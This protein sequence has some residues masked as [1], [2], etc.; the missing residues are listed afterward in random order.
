[1]TVIQASKA[2]QASQVLTAH[3]ESMESM[4]L[5]AHQ[6]PKATPGQPGLTAQ[7]DP[8]DRKVSRGSQDSGSRSVAHCPPL[9]IYRTAQSK[10]TCIWW[11]RQHPHTAGCGTRLRSPTSMPVPSKDRKDQPGLTGLSGLLDPKDRLDPRAIRA[12]RAR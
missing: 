6:E 4:G 8:L 10:A 5:T 12:I 3:Q 2:S 11:S 7:S 1:M 9:T